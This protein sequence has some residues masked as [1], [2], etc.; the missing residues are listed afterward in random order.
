M[1]TDPIWCRV[2]L[3]GP[4]PAAPVSWLVGGPGRPDL[5][6]IERLARMQLTATRRGGT[7]LVSEVCRDLG[8]LL[9]LAD[10]RHVLSAAPGAGAPAAAD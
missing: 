4:G 5:A 6:V 3:A 8:M 9:D 2:T 1:T 7:L 10:L